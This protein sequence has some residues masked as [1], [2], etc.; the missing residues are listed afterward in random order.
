MYSQK[1]TAGNPT[2]H[3]IEEGEISAHDIYFIAS[4][5]VPYFHT[6]IFSPQ[7]TFRTHHK[8]SEIYRR[9]SASRTLRPVF[10]TNRVRSNYFYPSRRIIDV[11]PRSLMRSV[12]RFPQ[13]KRTFVVFHASLHVPESG[14]CSCFCLLEICA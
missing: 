6:L 7:S 8:L 9:L 2:R 4:R 12:S 13:N 10:E 11:L 1:S 3:M 14:P 5:K